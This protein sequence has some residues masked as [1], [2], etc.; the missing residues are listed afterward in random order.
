VRRGC[1]AGGKRLLALDGTDHAL[2][3]RALYG[4]WRIPAEPPVVSPDLA[5]N[6]VAI[7]GL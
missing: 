3:Q 5:D 4:S 1:A 7:F 2:W 6:L